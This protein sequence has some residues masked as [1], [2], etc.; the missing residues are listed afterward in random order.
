MSNNN[1]EY[2][3]YIKVKNESARKR[4]GFPFAFWWKTE[5]SEAAATARLAVSM[6][7]AGFEP[8]DFAK[9][10]RVNFPVVNE[11][12][13]E[14]S[15]DTTFSQKYELGGED[16][17]TFMLIPGAPATDAHDEK[18][19]ECADDAGAKESGTDTSDNDECQDCEVSVATLPFPQRVLH[20]F[21][22]AAADK[23]YLHHATRAQRR[24]ITVLEMEQENSYIQNLLMVLRKSEQVEKLD[25]ATL[26]RL[27]EAIKTVFSVTQNHQPWEFENFVTAWLN[28]GHP[29]RGLLVKEWQK[30]NRV[31]RITRTASGANTGGGNLTDRGEGFIHDQ[32]SLARDVATGVLARSMDVDIY[33]LH[34]AHAKRVDEIVAENKPP[35]SVFR[36]KF[37]AMPGG[38]DYSRAIVVASVKEAPIGIEAIPARVTEYLNRVLTETDHANPDPLIVDIACGRTSQPMPVKGSANDDEEKPQPSGAM[39]DEPATPETMEPDTTEHHQDAQPLDAQSQVDAAYQ[40]ILAELHE[41]RK[42]IPPKNPVDVGKQLAA[43]R[44]EYIEGISDPNDPKWVHNDYSASNQDESTD[45]KDQEKAC[46]TCGKTDRGDCPDCGAVMGDTTY[47]EMFGAEKSDDGQEKDQGIAEP[48]P[49]H[50][51]LSDDFHPDDKDAHMEALPA[52]LTYE[53]LLTIAALQGLCANP[54]Y[55]GVVDE[56]PGFA[57]RIASDVKRIQEK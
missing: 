57:V 3:Y 51:E 4:P 7:D 48:H 1:T 50:V 49:E 39:A 53:Q 14:G 13:P 25:N 44:G 32:T 26:F 38:Q 12:P 9:P 43:A 29:D 16:G 17:K 54:S 41:A 28:A 2:S 42:N 27:T 21:T 56:I 45:D 33:D 19:E 10:V 8:T 11:L 5:S 30:G 52:Q 36:D 18:T 47:K 31:S 15:F 20:I 37:I 55:S 34:P 6:L 40:K 35:F 23:K 24:H 46:N 22:Y